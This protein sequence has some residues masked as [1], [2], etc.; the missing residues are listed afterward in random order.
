MDIQRTANNS[1]GSRTFDESKTTT[2][3]S[4]IPKEIAQALSDKNAPFH[5]SSKNKL[6]C[7]AEWLIILGKTS[8]VATLCG[9]VL[10]KVDT[11]TALMGVA[12]SVLVIRRCS[13]PIRQET[14]IK[15]KDLP[16]LFGRH[17][18]QFVYFHSHTATLKELQAAAEKNSIFEID[19]AWAHSAFNP[20]VEEGKP[21]IGHPEEFYT[22]HGKTFPAANVSLDEF[23]SFLKAHPGMKVLI[24]VKD[25]TVLPY[26]REL[27]TAIGPDRCIVHAFI[28]NWTQIPNET[29]PEPHWYREDINLFTLDAVLRELNIPLIANCRGFSND[30]VERNDMISQMIRDS[31]ACTSVISLGLYYPGAPLP[32]T[33][34]LQTINDAGYYAWVNGNRPEYKGQIGSMKHIAMADEIGPCTSF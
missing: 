3:E 17:Q 8:A 2:R 16:A 15:N 33:R 12:A 18:D 27:A 19:L 10:G 9:W 20:H 7:T 6:S 28:N 26:L 4:R 24:D 13:A 34:F 31:K 32:D 29:T 22:K 30:H 25:E 1:Y 11:L 23:K 14:L 5:T 21:Y